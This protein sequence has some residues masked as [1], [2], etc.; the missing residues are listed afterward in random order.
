MQSTFL[1][2]TQGQLY[3]CTLVQTLNQR[4]LYAA[5]LLLV[6]TAHVCVRHNQQ[7]LD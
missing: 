5:G 6:R 7:N 3:A 1:T 4:N 2:K